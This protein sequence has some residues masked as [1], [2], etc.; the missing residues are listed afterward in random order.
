MTLF[1]VREFESQAR[2]E[3][4]AH[5][6]ITV[7][8]GVHSFV[9]P[10]WLTRSADEG[11]NA[12]EFHSWTTSELENEAVLERLSKNAQIVATSLYRQAG[13]LEVL[14][15]VGGALCTLAYQ[16]A[17]RLWMGSAAV[18]QEEASGAIDFLLG[19][20]FPESKPAS[21]KPAIRFAVWTEDAHF[22]TR[23]VMDVTPWADA[24]LNYPLATREQL[25]R[26]ARDDFEAGR[27]G[28][29]LLLYGPPGTGKSNFLTTLAFEWRQWGDLQVIADP[30][31]VLAESEY[32]TRVALSRRRDDRWGLVVLEDSGN[33]F[34]VDADQRAGEHR[35]G[36]L[37]NCGSGILGNAS[38]TLWILTTNLPLRE[39]NAAVS[40]PGRCAAAIEFGSFP[41]DEA[42]VWFE[43]K[44]RPDL[45]SEVR[46]ELTL[47]EL[48]ALLRGNKIE[49]VSSRPVGFRSI[50]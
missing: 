8:G 38:R 43:G 25:A 42:R 48:Y 11:L 36:A 3:A 29:I 20:V 9:D 47:A 18:L 22:P 2:R 5:M 14:V 24:A 15:R 16:G 19:Q 6:R 44:G 10:T 21:D 27:D 35:L 12:R 45:A 13:K 33:L 49:P 46:G 28:R 37:L 39:F 23:S 31:T 4:T 41:A 17:G 30:A 40:R 50:S 34:G 7:E 26:L 1:E 32:L